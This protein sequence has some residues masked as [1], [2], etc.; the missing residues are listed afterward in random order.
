[1][2]AIVTGATKGIGLAIVNHLAANKYNLALCARNA[3]DLESLKDELA[4][5]H[6]ETKVHVLATDCGDPVKA[7]LFAEFVASSFEFADVLINNAGLYIPA[8]LLDEDDDDLQR[9]MQT[10]VLT[11]H[12]FSKY[13]GRKMRDAGKGHIVNICSTASINPVVSAASYSISKMALLGLTKLLRQ[14]LMPSGVKV[15]AVIPGATLT[16]SWDGTNI[17]V[18]QFIEP[19]DIAKAI[20]ACLAMS[21]GANVDEILIRPLNGNF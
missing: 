10:N 14:E 18:N 21:P 1:M 17:P 9:Q 4:T 12:F 2:N 15:T 6:P 3:D 7:G 20:I 19:D 8:T 13:F 5:K 16:G 11:P